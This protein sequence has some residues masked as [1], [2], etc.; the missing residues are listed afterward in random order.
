[1][2]VMEMLHP[3]ILDLLVDLGDIDTCALGRVRCLP[4]QSDCDLG[5]A[6]LQ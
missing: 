2:R 6:T 5:L 3:K 4:Q 1:M